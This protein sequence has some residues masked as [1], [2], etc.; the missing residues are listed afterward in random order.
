MSELRGAEKYRR[1]PD[2]DARRKRGSAEVERA[3]SVPIQS[4]LQDVFNLY[5]PSDLYRSWKTSCPFSYEHPDGGI[6]KNMRIYASNS[7]YC[8]AAHG[9]LTPVRMMQVHYGVSQ[10]R[11]ARM[12]ADRYG[13]VK[14]EPYWKRMERLVLEQATRMQEAGSPAHAVAALQ[15]ALGRV[16]GY[17]HKQFDPEVT[18]AMEAELERLDEVLRVQRDGGVRE[19]FREALRR[20]TEMVGEQHE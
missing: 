15:T 6:E 12:L 17:T 14:S 10:S 5:V 1:E 19:W 16:P 8:F 2:V 20:M 13:L 9:V 3:N 7:A 4:V 11:A 18:T